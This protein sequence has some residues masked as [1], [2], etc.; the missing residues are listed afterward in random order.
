MILPIALIEALIVGAVA[1]GLHGLIIG[2]FS[3]RALV[4]LWVA[5]SLVAYVG[6]AG[7][8]QIGAEA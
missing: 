3:W 7:P 6:L 1:S 4:A 5:L 2:S 8:I